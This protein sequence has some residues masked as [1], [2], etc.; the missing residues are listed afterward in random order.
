MR[1]A[2]FISNRTTFPQTFIAQALQESGEALKRNGLEPVISDCSVVSNISEAIKYAAWLKENPCDGVVAVFPNFGDE[3]SCVEA[4]RDANVPILFQAYPDELNALDSVTRRDA[5]CGKISAVNVFQQCRIPHSVFEPHTVHPTSTEFDANL[6]DFAAVCR[7]VKGM[8]RIRTGSIGT[9]CTPFKTVRF[10]ETTL[11]HYGITNEAFDF[12]EIFL[13]VESMRDDDDELHA[14]MKELRNYAAWPQNSGVALKNIS[15]LAVAIDRMIA[16]YHLDLITLRCW[17]ELEEKWKITPCVILSMLNNKKIIANC[18]VDTV[19]ALAM[20]ALSLAADAPAA[21]LDWNN[22]YGDN[23]NACILFHC[24]CIAADMMRTKGVIVDHAMFS[25][26]YGNGNGL[27]C[28]QGRMKPGVFTSAGGYTRDSKLTFFIDRGK[29]LNEEP[30]PE[31]FGCG[32]VAEF[33]DF[34]KKMLNLLHRGFPH[35]VSLCYGNYETAL[36][37][38]FRYLN[39]DVVKL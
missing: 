24:G 1:I 18:E 13:R 10:D 34:Q 23:K 26:I 9:R 32:G 16:D 39:Y 19:N 17:T 20:R 33:E 36:N 4:L 22:N 12:S 30:P 25:T 8:R 27:G 15:K 38:A 31:F 11:E 2:L 29:F 21:C 6:R 3:S 28:N 37:E 7:I 14:K 35:H 5:F